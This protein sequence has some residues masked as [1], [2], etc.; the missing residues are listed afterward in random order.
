MPAAKAKKP[1]KTDKKTAKK[2]ASKSA[3]KL[4]ALKKPLKLSVPT[5]LPGFTPAL[6]GIK[7]TAANQGTH[8]PRVQA[9]L[10]RQEIT[11]LL[12]TYCRAVDRGDENLLR[13]VYHPDASDDRGPGIF[14][15]TAQ[16]FVAW[17]MGVLH[18]VKLTH[19]LLTNIRIDLRGDTALAE[20]YFLAYHRLDK[21]TGKEDVVVGGRYLDRL[22]RR[23]GGPTG[24]WKI[25]HR[26]EINDWV[27]TM[28]AADIFYIQN[29]DAH[30][31]HRG[32][33][34]LS[35]HMDNFPA[36]HGRGQTYNRPYDSKSKK[37]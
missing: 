25:A 19:H 9:L 2:P 23:P 1:I 15:G 5:K 28:P 30:W 31:G 17:C 8:H 24:V 22:E 29:P 10:D 6:V 34:D 3:A 32:K 16:E 14:Q 27:R 13:S 7:K 33:T 11:D 21:P 36:G 26:K 12:H 20:S 18:N 4:V 35:Y 37:F